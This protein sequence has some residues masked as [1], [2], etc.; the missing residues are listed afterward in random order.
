MKDLKEYLKRLRENV[1]SVYETD[2]RSFYIIK[3]NDNKYK[4]SETYTPTLLADLLEYKVYTKHNLINYIKNK[5]A[6]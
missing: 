1:I 6:N 5:E 2:T 3:L 4:M